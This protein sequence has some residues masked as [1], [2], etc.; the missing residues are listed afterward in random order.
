MD[1]IK[2]A[3]HIID[4]GPEGG[5]RGGQIVGQGTPEELAAHNR[6]YTARFLAQTLQENGSFSPRQF[7]V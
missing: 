6:G 3:D 7:E 5:L 2:V 1:V 4:L